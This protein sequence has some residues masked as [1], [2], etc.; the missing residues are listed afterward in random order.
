MNIYDKIKER[1]AYDIPVEENTAGE[2]IQAPSVETPEEN[3]M[4]TFHPVESNE[5]VAEDDM[6]LKIKEEL[7]TITHYA[8]YTGKKISDEVGQLIHSEYTSDLVKAYNMVCDALL[9]ATPQTIMYIS[10]YYESKKKFYIFSPIPLVRNF[11]IVAILA[12]LSLMVTGLSS[13]V[14]AVELSKGILENDGKI[15]MLNL[16]FLS[17]AS[18]TGASF[19]LLSK[20]IREVKDATLSPEDSTY[21][22]IMLLMGM[23]SGIILSEG[24]SVNQVVLDDSIEVNRLLFAILGGFSSEIVYRILQSIMEKVQSLIAA[25]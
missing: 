24:V 25:I 18:V 9:P 21:Y 22:W 4:L 23:L 10:R 14:N 6:T 3:E 17:S 1:S 7:H 13:E 5:T 20:L 8:M 16:L 2:D 15:L 19:F 11:M 12:V